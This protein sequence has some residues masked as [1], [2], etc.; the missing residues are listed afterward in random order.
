MKTKH[1]CSN[2]HTQQTLLCS[3]NFEQIVVHNH[4]YKYQK[5]LQCHCRSSMSQI[6]ICQ[7][8]ESPTNKQWSLPPYNG[9]TLNCMQNKERST[10]MSTNDTSQTTLLMWILMH[11][12]H[13]YIRGGSPTPPTWGFTIV[14]HIINR[15]QSVN[16]F[17]PI[18]HH[19]VRDQSLW[20]VTEEQS[21]SCTGPCIQIYKSF[22]PNFKPIFTLFEGCTSFHES[23]R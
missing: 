9:V 17:S 23:F 2:V 1:I 8:W 4:Q 12:L 5:I 13:E 22:C 19:K 18:A 16:C 20:P 7:K 3:T 15:K 10:T 6:I 14:Y 11:S 21:F